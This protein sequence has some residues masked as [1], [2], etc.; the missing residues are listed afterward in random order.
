MRWEHRA[1]AEL[2]TGELYDVLKLRQEVEGGP[3]PDPA[4][5]LDLSYYQ[6]ALKRLAR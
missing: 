6:T 5:Y 2:T 3:A 4:K 1:F